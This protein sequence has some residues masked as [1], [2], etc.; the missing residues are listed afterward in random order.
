MLADGI[1]VATV[2]DQAG[3]ADP[4][5]TLKVYTHALKQRRAATG[6]RMDR[7]YGESVTPL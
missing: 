6:K 7:L 2:G 5:V 1:D 4:A 3:H